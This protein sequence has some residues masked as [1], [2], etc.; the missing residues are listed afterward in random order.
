MSKRSGGEKQEDI[1]IAHSWKRLCKFD[2]VAAMRK[3]WRIGDGANRRARPDWF[4]CRGS[5]FGS[6]QESGITCARRGLGSLSDLAAA[7]AVAV[8]MREHASFAGFQ[9]PRAGKTV[10]QTL[11]HSAL[12]APFPQRGRV[13]R[14]FWRESG[15]WGA[16]RSGI[17]ALKKN[18]L[19]CTLSQILAQS[20]F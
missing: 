15:V 7:V 19:K 1:W 13:Y 8:E 20:P 9:A 17:A 12:G 16:R 6:A 10:G 5:F 11:H 4:D 3:T 2:G 18:R 14:P